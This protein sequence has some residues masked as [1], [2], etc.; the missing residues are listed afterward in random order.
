MSTRIG[1]PAVGKPAAIGFG[2]IREATPPCGVT[3]ATDGSEHINKNDESRVRDRL[4]IGLKT[5]DVVAM[6]DDDGHDGMG[7]NAA[8]CF[9]NSLFDQPMAG[10]PVAVH[11]SVA[12]ISETTSWFAGRRQPAF[13]DLYEISGK[14]IQT[15]RIVAEEIALDHDVRHRPRPI[16]WHP[17][18]LEQRRR[19]HHQLVGPVS[20]R[21]R[22]PTI[23]DRASRLQRKDAG[24]SSSR[25]FPAS[26]R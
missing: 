5:S 12:P 15:V 9:R 19:E 8:A 14:L 25:K 17:G 18:P 13:F 20:L 2:V 3:P 22:R 26:L 1:S 16:A 10:Q 4:Q 21:H 24:N 7:E 11:V 6:A 23:V